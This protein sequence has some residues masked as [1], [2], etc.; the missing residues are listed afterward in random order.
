MVVATITA[1]LVKFWVGLVWFGLATYGFADN[2]GYKQWFSK[3]LKDFGSVRL[4][5]PLL[6]VG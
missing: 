2:F 5:L 4:W 3:N 6:I 1:G